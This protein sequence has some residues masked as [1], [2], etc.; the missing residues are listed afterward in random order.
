MDRI[1]SLFVAVDALSRRFGD[2]LILIAFQATDGA[3]AEAPTAT[4]TP[5]SLF[6]QLFGNPLVFMMIAFLLFWFIVIMPQ[7]RNYRRQQT[8]MAELRNN[9]RKNDRV[10]T[11]SGI[12]GVVVSV[13][14]DVGTVTMRI[15]ETNNTKMTISREAIAKVI[16]DE[17]K[18]EGNNA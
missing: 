15:D 14:A 18:S 12:H 5:N 9:L 2:A 16:R 6:Q 8:E 1:L 11:A 10:V 7:Q 3:G 13:A 4:G 17:A